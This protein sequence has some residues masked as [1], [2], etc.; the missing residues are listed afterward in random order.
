[1]ITLISADIGGTKTIIERSQY[2]DGKLRSITKQK[3]DS[4][5]FHCFSNMLAG[6]LE[7]DEKIDVACFAIAGPIESDTN[8]QLNDQKAKVTNLPW[9]MANLNIQETFNIPQVYFINDFQA[10][11]YAI[12]HLEAND[13]EVLQQGKPK[14]NGV[15]AVIGAGTGLGE[16]IL[17]FNGE[18]YEVIASEGG[19]QDFAPTDDMEMALYNEIHKMH[20]HVSYERILSGA[21]L[22]TLYKFLTKDTQPSTEEILN[23]ADP[24]AAISHAANAK[25]DIMAEKALTLF[26]KIYGAKAGNLA[27][28]CLPTAGIYITGGIAGKNLSFLKESEFIDSFNSKGRMQSLLKNIPVNIV[29]NQEAGLI[30]ATQYALSSILNNTD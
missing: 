27:L 14:T 21:G 19:H 24:A 29:T 20:E 22:V 9:E 6:F 17:V 4:A 11:G 18:H 26:M 16:A 13:I 3:Y 12:D 1:M 8:H 23:T 10:M 30:G 28:A 15:R 2:A 7:P 5:S 25:S